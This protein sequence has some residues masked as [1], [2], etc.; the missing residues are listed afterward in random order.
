MNRPTACLVIFG[1]LFPPA[2]P[3]TAALARAPLSLAECLE[4]ALARNPGLEVVRQRLEGA[5]ATVAAADAAGRVRVDSQAG[6]LRLEDPPAI[7]TPAGSLEL[8]RSNAFF[9]DLGASQVFY[10][11]G[12]IAAAGEEAR[13]GRTAFEASYETARQEL[14]LAI[15][16]TYY[17]TLFAGELVTVR[18]ASLD[19]LTSH[20][21]ITRERFEQ[22]A[23]SEYEVLR[24][25]VELANNR[26]LLVA[27]ENQQ[28]EARDRLT[29]LL[30]LDPDQPVD[31]RGVLPV[32]EPVASGPSSLEAAAD[33]RP[34]LA[35]AR[36]RERAAEAA[37]RAAR[38]QRRPTASW[39]AH[40]FA[41]S[42]EYLVATDSD[43]KINGLAGVLVR[44]PLLTGGERHARIAGAEATLAEARAE[45]RDLEG[46]IALEV[47]LARHGIAEA[48]AVL[49]AQGRVTEQAE[50]ALQIARVRYGNGLGTQLEVTD[51]QLALAEARVRRLRTL[52]DRA[53]ADAE[54]R[55]ALGRSLLTKGAD[56]G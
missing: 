4:I 17:A 11:G 38:A 12:A 14:A 48:E 19:Q 7:G 20:L 5:T 3:A 43:P 8:G 37:L 1:L 25:E 22:G 9:A 56:D 45:T 23:A 52:A 34:E 44:F 41:T 49:A 24:A 10:A 55:R 33:K 40:L 6:Y 50:K 51:A 47:R 36:A 27:A 29:R 16:R 42:P 2:V 54:L 13:A 28:A 53:V 31:V 32:P 30:G 26:P 39:V 21:K 15:H 18:R 46:A 35:T